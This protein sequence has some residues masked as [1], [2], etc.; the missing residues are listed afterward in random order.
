MRSK[1]AGARWGLLSALCAL[2]LVLSACTPQ[3]PA[4]RLPAASPK[5]PACAVTWCTAVFEDFNRA[6]QL[7]AFEQT[8]GADW[9]GYPD[10][11]SD[12]SGHG[13]YWSSKVLSAHDGVLDWWVHSEG[14]QPMTAAPLPQGYAGQRWGRWTVR[15]RAD[16]ISGFKLAFLLWPVS[17][18]WAEGE[19]DFPEGELGQHIYGF[20]HNVQGNPGRN[21]VKVDAA[22]S[23]GQ[24]HTA[25]IEWLPDHLTYTLDGQVIKRSTDAKAI[26]QVPMRSVL[27]VETDLEGAAPAAS[28]Q[29]HVQVD[30]VKIERWNPQGS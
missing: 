22:V 21:Q 9:A 4:Q 19:L 6:A 10:G 26:P 29:G 16:R 11:R 14:G 17:D 2:A 24:W 5:A 28:A 12:T 18:R 25:T 8:Y 1:P 30:W 23:M 3:R 27:Q 20:A 15:F 7:G 13:Q